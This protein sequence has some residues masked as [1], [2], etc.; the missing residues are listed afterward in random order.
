MAHNNIQSPIPIGLK[1]KFGV[2]CPAI[3]HMFIFGL[4]HAIYIKLYNNLNKLLKYIY[5]VTRGDISDRVDG[6]RSLIEN[7]R[8]VNERIDLRVLKNIL[9]HHSGR[10]RY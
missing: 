8:R 3:M 1:P 5:I 7:S 6:I 9:K 2:E 4:L 10:R